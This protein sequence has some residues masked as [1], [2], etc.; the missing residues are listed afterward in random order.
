MWQ[1]GVAC[2]LTVTRII[3]GPESVTRDVAERLVHG[4]SS[5]MKTKNCSSFELVLGSMTDYDIHSLHN[6]AGDSCGWRHSVLE[7]SVPFL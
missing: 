6:Y 5:K 4:I 3:L 7:L 2:F 1:P